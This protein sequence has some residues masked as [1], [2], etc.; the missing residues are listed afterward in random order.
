MNKLDES[1]EKNDDND[2][3]HGMWNEMFSMMNNVDVD[4]NF[5]FGIF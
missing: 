4:K 5:F 1:K 2:I 3:D